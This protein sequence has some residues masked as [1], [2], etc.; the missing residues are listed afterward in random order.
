MEHW[1]EWR[2]PILKRDRNTHIS[3]QSEHSMSCNTSHSYPDND[4]CFI[5]YTHYLLPFSFHLKGIPYLML[6]RIRRYFHTKSTVFTP[7]QLRRFLSKV[8]FF[9]RK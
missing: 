6:F 1:C 2:T 9:P 3:S 5:I 4:H 8:I 7:V